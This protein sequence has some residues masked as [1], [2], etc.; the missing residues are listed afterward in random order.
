L[1]LPAITHIDGSSRLQT[2]GDTNPRFR[3]LLQAFERRTGCPILLN[4]SFNLR[5]EPIVCTPIDALLC[6]IRSDID[7]LVME[8]SVLDR[9]TLPGSWLE[10]FRRSGPQPAKV[11]SEKIYTLL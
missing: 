6:F 2:V 9:S 8:D 5:G 7:C 1:D 3:R 10:W 11:V 4:T